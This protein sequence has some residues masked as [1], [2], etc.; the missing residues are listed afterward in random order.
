MSALRVR[1][2][3]S[4]LELG[5]IEAAITELEQ[6]VSRSDRGHYYLAQAYMQSGAYEKSRASYQRAVEI[7]PDNGQ[8]YYG[9]AMTSVRLG[10][11]EKAKQ[12]QEKFRQLGVEDPEAVKAQKRE[13]KQLSG[14]GRERSATAAAAAGAADIYRRHGDLPQ[15]ERLMQRAAMIDPTHTASRDALLALY[16]SSGRLEDARLFFEKLTQLQPPNARDHYQLGTICTRL[17][18]RDEA[19]QAFLTVTRHAPDPSIGHTALARLYLGTEWKLP[20]AKAAAQEAAQLRPS[21]QSYLL[22]AQV[23]TKLG[24][25]AEALAALERALKMDPQDAQCRR[26]YDALSEAG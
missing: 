19:E 24:E 8:A 22:L 10:Q 17:N 9:L 26:L 18:R 3:R 7:N 16:Q 6:A 1:L 12:Y 5:Q 11:P 23:C 13:P 4:L 25:R 2:G 20:A 15:A 21:P 14:L